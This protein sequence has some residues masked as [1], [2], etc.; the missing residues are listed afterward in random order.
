MV[1]GISEGFN[2][3]YAETCAQVT[4]LQPT[5]P[6]S[7]NN[8]SIV[9]PKPKRSGKSSGKTSAVSQRPPALPDAAVDILNTWFDE[10]INNPYPQQ[11]EKELLAQRCRL[12][13][14]QISAWFS[15]RRN[16]MQY[17]KPKRIQ[18]MLVSEIS[19]LINQDESSD[20]NQL[21]EKIC[22]KL[23]LRDINN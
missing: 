3:A 16:R 13:V 19:G 21:I 10:H 20:K 23:N 8:E 6:A 1:G 14:K 18:R 4:A 11:H 5:A 12:T 2:K 17:T 22:N 9:P 15:N 7:N